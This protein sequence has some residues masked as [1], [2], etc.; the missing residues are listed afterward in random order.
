MHHNYFG[1][2][3]TRVQRDL[4]AIPS[5][6]KTL[7]FGLFVFM[8]A[9]GVLDPFFSIILHQVIRNYSLTGL[10]YGSFFIV[11]A[12]FSAPVGGLADKVN[13]IRF[14]VFSILLYPFLGL[15][16]LASFFFPVA[17]AF[18]VLLFARIIHGTCSL[19]WVMAES[20]IRK[21]SPKGETSATF[22]LYVT[23][24]KLAFVLAPLIIIPLVLFFG[25]DFQN[26]HWLLLA[27]FPFS[28]AAALVISRVKDAGEPLMQGVEELVSKD[29]VFKKELEDLKSIGIVG[30]LCL[31]LAF[32]MRSLESILVFLVPLYALSIELGIIEISLLFGAICL[33]FLLSFFLAELSDKFGKANTICLG[34]LCAAVT[35]LTIVFSEPSHLVLIVA[36]FFLGL[37]LAV[38]QPA[39]NGLITDIT[40]RVNDGEITGLYMAVIMISGFLSA[41]TI[42]MLS[43]LFSLTFPFMALAVIL[44]GLALSTFALKSRI[45]VRI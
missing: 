4:G 10:V 1:F 7:I 40:P 2:L 8:M 36:C 6:V 45:V 18:I 30:Y 42:G 11:G 38:L 28:I 44:I 39:I 37:L 21:N 35:L 13:K 3:Y 12:V 27:L 34:F 33:P 16:Y 24:Q 32:F 29:R 25:L 15:F 9:W 31:T 17:L 26:L 5:G 43:D 22:G 41:V 23:F 19:F 20:F 14:T